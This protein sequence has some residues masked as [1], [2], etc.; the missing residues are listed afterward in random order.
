MFLFP[1]TAPRTRPER[2]LVDGLRLDPLTESEVVERVMTQ[3]ARAGGG[4]VSTPN[5]DH[6]RTYRR[7]PEL[8]PLL[9][10]ADIVVADGAPLVW[11]SRLCRTPVPARVAGSDLV[12]SLAAAAAAN[13]RSLFLLGGDPGIAEEAAVTLVERHP[14]LLVAGTLCPPRG[15]EHDPA[16]IDHIADTL[17]AAQPDLVYVALGFP[18]QEQLIVQLRERLPATWF[19]GVGISLSF[20]S[21]DVARAPRWMQRT[22]LEWLHRLTTDPRRLFRRYIMRDLP[23]V[24]GLLRRAAW[25]GLT[26]RG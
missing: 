1:T 3:L 14:E 20:I 26:R 8:R 6:F 5:A 7:H 23:F 10:S 15:F 13:R 11:A 18:K 24:T 19:I 21:G 4:W 16:E 2:V 22:G 17:V 25:R 9:D 12:W